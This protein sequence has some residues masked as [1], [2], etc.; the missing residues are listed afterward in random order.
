MTWVEAA[1]RDLHALGASACVDAFTRFVRPAAWAGRE[2]TEPLLPSGIF[3]CCPCTFSAVIGAGAPELRFL[4]EPQA[5]TPAAKTYWEMG[6]AMIREAGAQGAE[7]E[8]LER[9]APL[10][11]PSATAGFRIWIGGLLTPGGRI[12]YKV[13]LCPPGGEQVGQALGLLGL[14]SRAASQL[15]GQLTIFSLD[16]FGEPPRVKLYALQRDVRLDELA[17]SYALGGAP[18]D[19]APAF[20]RALLG[21]AA[22]PPRWWLTAHSFIA[23]H[24]PVQSAVHLGLLRDALDDDEVQRRLLSFASA[25]GIDPSPYLRAHAAL[26][27][28][29][30]AH[31][32]VS[33]QVQGGKPRLTVYFSP[34]PLASRAPVPRAT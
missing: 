20:A 15:P 19:D 23:G 2:V 34:R 24:R 25:R 1:V 31:H 28:D 17:R 33:F 16:L 3:H 4:V 30:R 11:V 13:Y 8:R 5:A 6:L 10:F 14:S 21:P 27:T 7:L 32:F 12:H 26:R 18:A 29:A 9:I 22:E